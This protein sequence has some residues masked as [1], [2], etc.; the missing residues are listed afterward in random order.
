MDGYV[1]T[2]VA[3][4]VR[5]A[6][7]TDMTLEML[8]QRAKSS[9]PVAKQELLEVY[10]FFASEYD[11]RPV[12]VSKLPLGDFATEVARRKTKRLLH[13]HG[14]IRSLEK[15]LAMLD[16]RGIILVNDYGQTQTSDQEGF[17]HQ[18]F[19]ASTFVGVNF[20]LLKE[21]F[22]EGKCSAWAESAGDSRG[23]H[24]RLL[25]HRLG[26]DTLT[27]FHERF[28]DSGLDH[29]QEP[30]NG[31]ILVSRSLG[32]HYDRKPTSTPSA[33]NN[34]QLNNVTHGQRPPS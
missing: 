14:A 7:Y 21:Y 32:S 29:L 11:Y 24:S 25:G 20:P 16:N 3:R 23:I 27:T 30:L 18:R 15:L 26:S 1:R 13:S 9:E 17:E 19:G 34:D 22:G 8:R 6:D 5:L 4:N 12:D 33:M 2:L 31:F 10:G 28:S